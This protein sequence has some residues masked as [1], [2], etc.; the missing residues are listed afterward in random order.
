MY[1]IIYV[2][3]VGETITGNVTLNGDLTLNIALPTGSNLQIQVVET[4]TADAEARVLQTL[5]LPN[6]DSLPIAYQITYTPDATPKPSYSLSARITQ[7]NDLLYI[8]TEHV[9]AM[10]TESGSSIMDIP[11]K[12]TR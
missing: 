2:V 12:R 3:T 8:N 11:V 4:S 7:G 5:Q 1:L 6:V 10:V 9:S